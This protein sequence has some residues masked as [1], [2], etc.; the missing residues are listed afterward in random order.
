MSVGP[1][2]LLSWLGEL[3]AQTYTIKTQRL[4]P[5]VEGALS[6]GRVLN[7]T[8]RFTDDGW[9]IEVDQRHGVFVGG[10]VAS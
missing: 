8:L 10:T 1:Q 5:G 9:A 4:S 2:Y 6:K 3:L 7:R